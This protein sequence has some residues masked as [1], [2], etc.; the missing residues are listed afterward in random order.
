MTIEIRELVI[1]ARV[2]ETDGARR[3]DFRER[4]KISSKLDPETEARLVEQIVTRVL[5]ILDDRRERLE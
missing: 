3:S 1:E 5:D 2:S 4:G